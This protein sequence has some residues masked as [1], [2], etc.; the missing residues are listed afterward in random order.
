MSASD[1]ISSWRFLICYGA[2][3]FGLPVLSVFSEI[4]LS[5]N[6]PVHLFVKGGLG[7]LTRDH[8]NVGKQYCCQLEKNG[9]MKS[10]S[11]GMPMKSKSGVCQEPR[12]HRL[13]EWRGNQKNSKETKTKKQS[14]SIPMGMVPYGS[15]PSN[16]GIPA[17]ESR[18]AAN[19]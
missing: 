18:W 15:A 8:L 9:R 14:A 13:N 19:V 7:I 2:V 10:R 5:W 4:D 6:L 12:Y 1:L 17:A 16:S 11:G 3:P